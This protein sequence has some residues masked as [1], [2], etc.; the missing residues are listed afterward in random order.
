MRQAAFL[1]LRMGGAAGLDSE[2]EGGAV[3]LYQDQE[4]GEEVG[5]GRDSRLHHVR[6]G[7]EN[8]ACGFKRARARQGFVRDTSHLCRHEDFPRPRLC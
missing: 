8:R 2:K 1:P 4:V 5:M 7:S 3:S 6:T